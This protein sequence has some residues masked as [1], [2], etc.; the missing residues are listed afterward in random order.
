MHL[1]RR[2]AGRAGA[3]RLHP[4]RGK[5]WQVSFTED[6]RYISWTSTR[7]YPYNFA[8]PLP[9][10][11]AFQPGHGHETYVPLAFQFAYLPSDDWK[12]EFLTRSGYV[13]AHQTTAG[14]DGSASTW[15]DTSLS[16][17]VTYY[18][19]NGIQP[20]VS[21][22]LN[23]PTGSAA[24]YGVGEFARM[25]PDIFDISVF[26]EGLNV[27]PTARLQYADRR[28]DA[29]WICGRPHGAWQLQSRR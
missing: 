28:L 21:V 12:V 4:S 11:P 19:I 6:T 25:D 5:N 7:G 13:T 15:T 27:A 2:F 22:A 14:L 16:S 29:V 26:G 24:L 9:G 1:V 3:S 10:A 8:S 18:G 23:L 20:Y 17:T